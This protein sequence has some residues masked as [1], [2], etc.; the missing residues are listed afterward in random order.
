MKV[1]KQKG[2]E[3]T[4]LLYVLKGYER[5]YFGQAHKPNWTILYCLPK[6]DNTIQ[7][8]KM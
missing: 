2:S 4:L 6:C 3:K 1:K 7:Y 5:S 8:C